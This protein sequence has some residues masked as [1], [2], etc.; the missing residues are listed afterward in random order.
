MGLLTL[1]VPKWNREK[2]LDLELSCVELQGLSEVFDG[3]RAGVESYS[4]GVRKLLE[5][6]GNGRRGNLI[7]IRFWFCFTKRVAVQKTYGVRL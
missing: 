6:G 5:G 3:A 1:L 4:E 7:L 2:D